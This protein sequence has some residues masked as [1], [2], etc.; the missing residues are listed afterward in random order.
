MD[1]GGVLS[2]I[3]LWP[4]RGVI[5]L[6]YQL[7]R[8][9][10]SRFLPLRPHQPW[11]IIGPQSQRFFKHLFLSSQLHILLQASFVS[12]HP[13]A[14]SPMPAWNLLNREL[15]TWLPSPPLAPGLGLG[16]QCLSD[17]QGANVGFWPP[18]RLP[19]GFRINST[20][21]DSKIA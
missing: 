21:S 13:P 14:T 2:L 3:W 4:P 11:P 20:E 16:S 17:D 6:E 18:W 5:S 10:G 9:S 19:K 1:P 15:L 12:H 7:R 8:C